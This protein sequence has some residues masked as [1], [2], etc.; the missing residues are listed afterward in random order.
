MV[1]VWQYL[2][3]KI[4]HDRMYH[5]VDRA[6]PIQKQNNPALS[7]TQ[8]LSQMFNRLSKIILPQERVKN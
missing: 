6:Q 3:K 4:G 7:R 1:S 2:I 8:K 5:E